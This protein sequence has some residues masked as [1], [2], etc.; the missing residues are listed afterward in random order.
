MERTVGRTHAGRML[1]Q[2][3][4]LTQDLQAIQYFYDIFNN[5]ICGE[6]RLFLQFATG[7]P[8]GFQGVDVDVNDRAQKCVRQ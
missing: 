6:Q 7:S 8:R 4:R 2:G 5:S 1:P 3:P